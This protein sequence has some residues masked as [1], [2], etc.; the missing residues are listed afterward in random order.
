MKQEQN[1]FL[2]PD[3]L[4]Q[5]NAET[6]KRDVEPK[7]LHAPSVEEDFNFFSERNQ[8][9]NRKLVN[10]YKKYEVRGPVVG[11]AK[12]SDGTQVEIHITTI[13]ENPKKIVQ[14]TVY[15]TVHEIMLGY[16]KVVDTHYGKLDQKYEERGLH[17]NSYYD[18]PETR[19]KDFLYVDAMES[20]KAGVGKIL[21]QIAVERSFQL[22][23]E[24]RVGL[25]VGAITGVTEHI[26]PSATSAVFHRKFGFEGK[27]VFATDNQHVYPQRT[28]EGSLH[29][30]GGEF[31]EKITPIL[32]RRW[33][34]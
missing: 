22:G 10:E 26:E 6:Q 8:T 16:T 19:G 27:D 30:T 20:L 33:S 29:H 17:P 7:E 31:T 15:D 34:V 2:N 32:E 3:K 11:R 5:E 24:G 9:V 1:Q 14:Y 25:V 4:S 13:T 12:L 21:H 23:F 28:Q 18:D